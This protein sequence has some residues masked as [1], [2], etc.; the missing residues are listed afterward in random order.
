MSREFR[1]YEQNQEAQYCGQKRY[2]SNKI[3]A[4]FESGLETLA[5]S[6][7]KETPKTMKFESE[8]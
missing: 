7:S 5:A 4:S 3:D 2:N 6:G 8:L 1:S